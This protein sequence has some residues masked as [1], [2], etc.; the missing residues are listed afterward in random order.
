MT[1]MT[2]SH[3]FLAAPAAAREANWKLRCWRRGRLPRSEFGSR[4]ARKPPAKLIDNVTYQGAIDEGKCAHSRG[5][6]SEAIEFDLVVG[7]KNILPD[8]STIPSS[9]HGCGDSQECI[10]MGDA[11]CLAGLRINYGLERN[12]GKA[13]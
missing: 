10:L 9:E 11:G 2:F 4:I 12:W 3:R 7:V 6:P 8:D 13:M 5:S 1:L